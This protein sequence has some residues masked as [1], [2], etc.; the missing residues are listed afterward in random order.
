ML[1]CKHIAAYPDRYLELFKAPHDGEKDTLREFVNV[2]KQLTGPKGI[3]FKAEDD[4]NKFKGDV[5]EVLAEIFFTLS[6]VDKAYGLRDY[7]PVDLAEDYGV[8]GE[9]IN[10]NGDLSMVQVKFRGNHTDASTFPTYAEIARTFASGV[11]QRNLDP[12]KKSTLFVFTTADNVSY[13][14]LAVFEK[15]LVVISYEIIQQAIDNNKN[16]WTL[17][18]EEI[19]N[20]I[21]Y[22]CGSYTI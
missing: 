1:L 2:V 22:H 14:C 4:R 11:I 6:K 10:D 3:K 20:Y 16:F 17:A 5:L 15:K 13:Q 7:K 19:K 21:G 12:T 9:G 18:Y 8:D